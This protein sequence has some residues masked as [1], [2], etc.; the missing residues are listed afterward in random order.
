M[1]RHSGASTLSHVL[2]HGHWA[3]DQLS[4]GAFWRW[5]QIDQGPAFQVA[6]LPLWIAAVRAPILSG[7]TAAPER[8][9]IV[10]IQPIASLPAGVSSVTRRGRR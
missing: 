6:T 7:G 4:C 9:S 1:S 2:W 5:S 8:Q 3:I 10:C